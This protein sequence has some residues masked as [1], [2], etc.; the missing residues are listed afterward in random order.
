MRLPSLLSLLVCALLASSHCCSVAAA[1]SEVTLDLSGARILSVSP[2]MDGTL[3]VRWTAPT[4][5]TY[6]D[7]SSA[8]LQYTLLAETSSSQQSS[9]SVCE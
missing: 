2:Q 6:N 9:I 8:A 1:S 5:A 4:A 7:S 3:T